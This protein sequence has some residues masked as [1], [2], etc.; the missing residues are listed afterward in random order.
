MKLFID[1]NILVS[2]LN[3]EYPVFTYSSRILSLSGYESFEIYTS[4]ICLAIAWYFAEKKTTAKVARDKIG[5]L[6]E[7]IS[8]APATA[9]TVT[10]TLADKRVNDFEDGLKY[11]SAIAAGCNFIITEDPGD[12]YFSKVPVCTARDFFE[13]HVATAK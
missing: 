6:C 11:Y 8:I 13:K 9:A 2:V 5:I 12:F 3:K 10:E 1:A 4:P 7:H